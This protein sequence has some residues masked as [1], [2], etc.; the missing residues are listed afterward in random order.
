M[1]ARIIK[2]EANTAYYLVNYILSV[3]CRQQTKYASIK[4]RDTKT[5][6]LFLYLNYR[7]VFC[8]TWSKSWRIEAGGPPPCATGPAQQ[9]T[10]HHRAEDERISYIIWHWRAVPLVF[11]GS[12][13]LFSRSRPNI[14][15]HF[16][17]S[18]LL[19]VLLPVVIPRTSS[20]L[21]ASSLA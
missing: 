11:A 19:I 2:P 1:C 15:L 10:R 14:T 6:S 18:A 7:G 9:V 13:Q 5:V 3:L 17:L 4:T 21:P 16:P 8:T 12:L 20:V